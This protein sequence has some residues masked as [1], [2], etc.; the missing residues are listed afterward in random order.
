VAAMSAGAAAVVSLPAMLPA[1]TAGVNSS[2]R[3]SSLVS[4]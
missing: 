2:D 4:P 1:D 3:V